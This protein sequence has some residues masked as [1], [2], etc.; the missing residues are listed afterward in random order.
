M[1]SSDCMEP[2]HQIINVGPSRVSGRHP[3]EVHIDNHNQ[4]FE[5]LRKHFRVS[6]TAIDLFILYLRLNVQLHY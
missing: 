3:S 1:K 6:N 5:I 4:W 2:F